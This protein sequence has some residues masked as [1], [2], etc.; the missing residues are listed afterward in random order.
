MQG[1]PDLKYSIMEYCASA[2]ITESIFFKTVT[3]TMTFQD[4]GGFYDKVGIGIG[5]RIVVRMYKENVDSEF[6]DVGLTFLVSSI[7]PA[8]TGGNSKSRTFFIAASTKPSHLNLK[9]RVRR[10][11]KNTAANVAKSVIVGYL[12]ADPEEFEVVGADMSQSQFSMLAPT[13]T[14]F[15]TLDMIVARSTAVDPK[16]GSNVVCYQSIDGQYRMGTLRSLFESGKVHNYKLFPTKNMTFQEDDYYR[17]NTFKQH[18]HADVGRRIEDGLLSNESVAYDFLTRQFTKASFNFLRD[19][20]NIMVTGDNPPFDPSVADRDYV[21]E[22]QTTFGS[23]TTIEY[24]PSDRAYGQPEDQISK[25]L[26]Y[27]KAQRAAFDSISYSASV[28]GNPDL[29]AGDTFD[30]IAPAMY[31]TTDVDPDLFFSGKFLVASVRHHIESMEEVTTYVD[32]FKDGYD[33]PVEERMR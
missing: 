30:V 7:G 10:A 32:L 6:R 9:L 20:R 31:Q 19:H 14:P 17:F 22:L 8:S 23:S 4:N 16:K 25:R 1:Q 5:D 33:L 26:V 27:D 18:K 21:G 24:R 28:I 11:F 2:D 15:Q 29:R 13:L 12:G 3:L